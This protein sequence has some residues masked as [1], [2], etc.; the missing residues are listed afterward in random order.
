VRLLREASE[1]ETLEALARKSGLS[2]SR[3]S[4]L[5]TEQVG[6]SVTEFRNR[7][8]VERFIELYGDGRRRSI[9][10]AALE[11]GFGSYPQFYRVFR[12]ATGRTPAEHARRVHCR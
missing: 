7:Q 5:F 6:L 1:S 8:R 11:A 4:R 9:S 3:L 12:D 10:E 2:A